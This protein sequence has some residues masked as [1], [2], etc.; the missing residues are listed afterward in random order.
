MS[1]KDMFIKLEDSCGS[2][3]EDFEAVLQ[4]IGVQTV[5]FAVD[6]SEPVMKTC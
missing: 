4:Q 3:L 2:F 1:C 5:D 6:F